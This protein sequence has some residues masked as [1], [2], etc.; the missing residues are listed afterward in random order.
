MISAL[1]G[2]L[3]RVDEDRVHLAVGPMLVELLVPAADV[4]E[5]QAGLG[6][7]ITFH[8]LFYIEGDPNRGNLEPRI[9]G[10][11]RIEQRR[12][13]EL[14]TTVSGIGTR[15]ALRALTVPTGQIAHA[16]ETGN[17]R[18]LVELPQIGKRLAEQIIATL[19]GKVGAFSVTTGEKV[20]PARGRRS[21]L[22][23]DAI[24][25]LMSLGERRPDA[26]ALLDR[27]KQ[28]NPTLTTADALL[29][30]MLRVR[31]VRA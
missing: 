7:Q 11:L 15:K 27:V 19:A 23:E 24:A 20:M 18:F 3:K 16:I 1:T 2:E 4:T 14:F 30:E 8:T 6:E 9:I 12:F 26:E 31:T 21:E 25:G 5:L 29:R 28:S 13:F 17:T 10:F 22:E